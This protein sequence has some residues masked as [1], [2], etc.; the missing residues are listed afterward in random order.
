MRVREREGYPL[1][2][3]VTGNLIEREREGGRKAAGEGRGERGE[4]ERK[5]RRNAKALSESRCCWNYRGLGQAVDAAG[6]SLQ[7]VGAVGGSSER[8]HI[9]HKVEKGGQGHAECTVCNV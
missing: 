7:S 1:H 3:C 6:P 4:K 5:E 9:V 2:C 8:E